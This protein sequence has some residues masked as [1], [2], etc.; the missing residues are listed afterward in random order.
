V[1]PRNFLT[2]RGETRS[3][4]TALLPVASVMLSV[5]LLEAGLRVYH[6]LRWNVSVV[7]GQP[8]DMGGLSPLSIDAELGWR[9][10]ENYR[11]EGVKNSFDGSPYAVKISQD[12][13]G[14]RSF[15]SGSK[16]RPRLLVIGDSFTQASEVSDDKT[17]YATLG[18]LLHLNIVAY[19]GGGYGTLQE[20]MIFDKY[21]ETIKPDLILWQYSTND[22]IN[23]SPELETASR[24]NNNGLVR[25]Y[26]VNQRIDYILP[27]ENVIALRRLA[28]QYC[29]ICYVVLNRLAKLFAANPRTTVET[30]TGRQGP[31]N[32]AFRRSV[33]IT[34]EIMAM[35]QRRTRPV[36]VVAFIV[37][38]GEPYGPEYEEAFQELSDRYQIRLFADIEGAVLSAE[39]SGTVVRA[40]DGAHWNETGHRLAGEALAVAFK[41]ACLLDLCRRKLITD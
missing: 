31:A 10:T 35:V 18:R 9:A 14:F 32:A 38:G 29:R 17:Y 25:P 11:Y 24:I 22:F 26:W 6:F 19:G 8:R 23:N 2:R 27:K 1:T 7:D 3:W 13:H 40:A 12:A 30:D 37:G 15:D 36:P 21:F 20:W 16:D 5:L 4:I 39:R 33:E 34:G 41:N 28:I